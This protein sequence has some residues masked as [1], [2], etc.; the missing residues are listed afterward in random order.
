MIV[1]PV[2]FLPDAPKIMSHE[3]QGE[4]L[5]LEPQELG[6]VPVSF[7]FSFQNL[8][9]QKGFPPKGQKPRGVQI[10]RMKRPQAHR[11]NLLPSR[12][13]RGDRKRG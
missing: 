9:G 8:L 11:K 1:P 5:G 10:L 7:R 13:V 2:R 12:Q 6:M 3:F 4:S